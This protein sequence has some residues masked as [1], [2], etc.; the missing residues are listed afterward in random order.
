MHTDR[1][2]PFK[3]NG[4]IIKK[5]SLPVRRRAI[6]PARLLT[7]NLLIK[8]LKYPLIVLILRPR[9]C[10]ISLLLR[11]VRRSVAIS[12]SLAI[13]FQAP[14]KSGKVDI[15]LGLIL[16]MVKRYWLWRGIGF[17]NATRGLNK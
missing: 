10:A 7:S 8:S 9:A 11:S 4:T 1:P 2:P 5:K 12:I 15:I 16:S 14:C 6:T 3:K 13:Q 17:F